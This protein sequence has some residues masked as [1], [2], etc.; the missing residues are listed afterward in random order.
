VGDILPVMIKVII[1]DFF[2]VFRT[3]GYNRWLK[4]RGFERTGAFLFAS[5]RHDRGETSDKQ[6]FQEVADAAG[7]TAEQAEQEMEASVILNEELVEYVETLQGKYKLAL[8]SNSSSDYLRNELHK[9]DLERYF[10]EI[11]I[12]SEVGLIKPEPAI[13]EHVMEKLGAKPE[14]CIFTD[15]NPHNVEAA[16]RLGIKGIVFVDVPSLKSELEDIVARSVQQSV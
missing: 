12:S 8:L 1:F 11:V 2:D 15:D 7:E 4:Q 16:E 3:D 9:Y 14:E 5:Q 6:F 13:F 10:D